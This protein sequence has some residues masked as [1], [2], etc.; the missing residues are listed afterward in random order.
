MRDHVA[1]PSSPRPLRTTSGDLAALDPRHR[2][3]LD[4]A[5]FDEARFLALAATLRDGNAATRRDVRNRIAGEVTAPAEDELLRS[6]EPGSAEESRLAAVGDAAL[7]RGELAFCVLAGGMATRMGGV[8]K[9]LVEAVDGKSFLDLRLAENRTVS[10]RARSPVPLWLMVSDATDEPTRAAL[11]K[12]GA[13]PHVKTFLQD[14]SLRLTPEGRLFRDAKGEPSIYSTGHGDTIDA[15]RRSGL[16]R[17]FVDAG[18]KYVWI[19]N[20]DNLGAAI[21]RALL[22]LF[23]E[24]QRDVMVEVAEKEAGDKGGI[25][26]HAPAPDGKRRLQVLEEFRLPKGFDA[27]SVR[28]FNTNTF[29]VRAPRLLDVEVTWG[30]FEVEKKVDGKTAL[31]FERLLQEITASLDAAY[32]RIPRHGAAARFLPA[33]DYDELAKRKADIEEVAR[34]RGMLA[35]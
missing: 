4:R 1:T 29:L 22:G 17:A 35:G 25:P 19:A 20:L 21:D 32:V 10:E 23:I 11:A 28:V 6:P 7:R 14:A 5:G 16:L 33:K 15:L 31:Q 24:S 26:V 34:A 13:P 30:W 18:G 12:A 8:V 3:E 2:A 9:A 27:E